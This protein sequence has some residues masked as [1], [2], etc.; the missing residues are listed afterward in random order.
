[1][2]KQKTCIVADSADILHIELNHGTNTRNWVYLRN[3]L[4]D[5][6]KYLVVGINSEKTWYKVNWVIVRWFVSKVS[7]SGPVKS[8]MLKVIVIT[9]DAVR[10]K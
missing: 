3:W 2:V 10:L 1:M 5:V 4:D 7:F 9:V 8:P 6:L